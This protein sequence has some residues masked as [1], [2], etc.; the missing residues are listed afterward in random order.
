MWFFQKRIQNLLCA[1]VSRC[2][3]AQGRRA[4]W[5]FSRLEGREPQGKK[6]G[7]RR[8]ACIV[9]MK[10][11]PTMLMKTKDREN[12]RWEHPTMLMKINELYR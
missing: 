1:S 2:R 7:S 12:Q 9:N 3:K 8:R 10:E 11:S 4:V 6:C 5:P